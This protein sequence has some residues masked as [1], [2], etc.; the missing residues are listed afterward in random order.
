MPTR[1]PNGLE[2]R[3]ARFRQ[4]DDKWYD[5]VYSTDTSP[6]YWPGWDIVLGWLSPE[7]RLADFGCGHGQF[8]EYLV[9]HGYNLVYGADYSAVAIDLAKKRLP[10]HADKFNQL[11]LRNGSAFKFNGYDVALFMET[12]EHVPDDLAVLSYVPSGKR[13]IITLPSFD[14][15]SHYRHFNSLD[16]CEARYKLSIQ[17]KRKTEVLDSRS[18]KFWLLD[19]VR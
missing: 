12:L 11:D 19:A 10:A 1:K 6:G 9:N 13:V 15:T 7:D 14:Y 8:D 17:I 16:E 2:K 4:L 3:K 18:I 5:E